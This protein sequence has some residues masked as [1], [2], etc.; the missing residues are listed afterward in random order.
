MMIK[1]DWF[2][3]TLGVLCGVFLVFLFYSLYQAEKE[4]PKHVAKHAAVCAEHGWTPLTH[5]EQ[6]GKTS[7]TA[8]FCKDDKG[9]MFWPY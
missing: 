5:T 2:L 6:S 4:Y 7:V 8:R 3:G 9:Q 1:D